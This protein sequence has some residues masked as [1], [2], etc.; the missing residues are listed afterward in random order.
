LS[1]RQRVPRSGRNSPSRG[2]AST[3]AQGAQLAAAVGS[4]AAVGFALNA[5]RNL[6]RLTMPPSRPAGIH[7]YVSILLPL[8]NERD[9]AERCLRALLAQ[10]GLER[11]EI[12]VL[13]DGSTDGTREAVRALVGDKPRVRTLTAAP[14][15]RGWLGKSSA[16]HQLAVAAR[17]SVYVYLDADVVL[18]PDAVAS[19]VAGLRTSRLDLLSALPRHT[20]THTAS[21]FLDPMP[22]WVRFAALPGALA[23]RLPGTFGASDGRLLAVDADAYWRSGG[24]AAG[25][26]ALRDDAAL[27]RTLRR[28]GGRVGTA[29]GTAIAVCETACAGA[30]GTDDYT[31]TL[32]TAL[33]H[34]LVTASA[35]GLLG[36]ASTAA[37]VAVAAGL[38]R[39]GDRRLCHVGLLGYAALVA[40]RAAVARRLRDPAWPQ[41]LG[42]PAISAVYTAHTAR[43]VLRTAAGRL[44]WKDRPVPGLTMR[45]SRWSPMRDPMPE[46]RGDTGHPTLGDTARRLLTAMSRVLSHPDHHRDST[47]H[48]SLVH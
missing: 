30:A 10:S 40:S 3:I 41:A 19:L 35:V 22:H 14:P 18:T 24:H 5:H 11:F 32:G 15:P 29:D 37:P 46:P 44:S 31:R 23:D 6:K 38:R 16:C 43:A 21:R 2:Y 17:G 39:G 13:D 12:V 34:P 36:W 7:E 42:H 1:S 45:R 9:R 4:L 25:A 8:R 27:A 33:G 28:R 26:R 47:R 48:K 20:A